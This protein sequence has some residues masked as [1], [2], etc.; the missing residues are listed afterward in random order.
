LQP[1]KSL[2]RD[3]ATA[4]APSLQ[5]SRNEHATYDSNGYRKFKNTITR[6]GTLQRS[7]APVRSASLRPGL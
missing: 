5:V 2:K 1:N 6:A 3:V 4:R 7:L